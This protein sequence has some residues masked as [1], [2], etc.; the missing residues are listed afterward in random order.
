MSLGDGRILKIVIGKK[1]PRLG[2]PAIRAF[3]KCAKPWEQ[4]S[5]YG[6]PENDERK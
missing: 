3:F 2:K 4:C 6:K 5:G 1:I